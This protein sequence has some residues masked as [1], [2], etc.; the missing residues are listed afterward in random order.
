MNYLILIFAPLLQKN[1]IMVYNKHIGYRL[2]GDD[3]I[4]DSDYFEWSKSNKYSLDYKND[5]FFEKVYQDLNSALIV[6]KKR[7]VSVIFL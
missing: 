6:I 1:G 7:V 3:L 4:K 2:Q 5:D